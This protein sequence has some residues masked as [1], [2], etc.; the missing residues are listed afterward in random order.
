M[1]FGQRQMTFESLT[2]CQKLQRNVATHDLPQDI[3][4]RPSTRIDEVN[5]KALV[6]FL[7]CASRSSMMI[8]RIVSRDRGW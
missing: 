6:K 4:F 2:L 3:F 1:D 8:E 7:S 5:K